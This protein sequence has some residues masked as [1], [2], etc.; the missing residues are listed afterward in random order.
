M[1]SSPWK[2][3]GYCPQSCVC[4]PPRWPF[5]VRHPKCSHRKQIKQWVRKHMHLS[6]GLLFFYF[7]ITLTMSL[8]FMPLLLF[9][10][11]HSVKTTSSESARTSCGPHSRTESRAATSRELACGTKSTRTSQWTHILTYKPLL[12]HAHNSSAEYI[13]WKCYFGTKIFRY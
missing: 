4:S 6:L 12:L 5:F 1:A 11:S 13:L 3:L 7:E 10:I 9:Q 2:S 8:Y